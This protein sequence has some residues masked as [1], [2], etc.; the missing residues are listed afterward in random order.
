MNPWID[1]QALQNRR[2]FFGD[3]G[4]RL[5]GLA[6][7]FL[8]AKYLGGRA[9]A[10]VA[11]ERVHPPLPGLPHFAPR[12]KNLIYLHMNGGPS[13]LDLWD[14]KPNLQAQFD[15]DLPDSVRMGQRITTMTSGQAR[16]PVAPSMYKFT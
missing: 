13:Q 10:T 11:P 1:Y 8:G 4:L 5:G 15:K 7:A 16:L 14:Y 3:S 6:L 9:L 12:A 2:Q